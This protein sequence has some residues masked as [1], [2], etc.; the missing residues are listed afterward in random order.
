MLL[1]RSR[2]WLC[3]HK[4]VF[5]PAI[6]IL[7]AFVGGLVCGALTLRTLHS[8]QVEELRQYLN[9]FLQE[10]KPFYE[11]SSVT[12]FQAWC[13]ILVARL[14]MLGVL[15]ILGLTVVGVPLITLAV[16]IR[17]FI[18]GFTIGFLVKEQSLRGLLLAL[19]AVLPQNLCYVPALLGA[20]SIAFYFSFSLLRGYREGS[21]LRGVLAYTLL[22]VLVLMITLVGTWIEAYFVPG[23]VRLMVS[24][25]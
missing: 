5:F 23:L 13:R 25:A 21:V 6:L 1:S 7:G 14:P 19:V 20:G 9:S 4:E 15:W 22:F 3:Q 12:G 11:T 18:L 16:G 17:G 2:L 10:L 8:A 24:I